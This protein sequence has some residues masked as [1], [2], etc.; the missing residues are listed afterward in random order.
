[1]MSD[2]TRTLTI[3]YANG[4]VEKFQFEPQSKETYNLAA[5]IQEILNAN[6]IVL[7][8]GDSMKIIPLSQV[9]S[10]EISPVP[11]KLPGIAIKNVRSID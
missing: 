9:Q 8:L 5:Q 3:R 1:M 7:D 4:N 11:D 6:Q 10:A 2:E